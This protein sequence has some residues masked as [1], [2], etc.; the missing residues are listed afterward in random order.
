MFNLFK[1]IRPP[2]PE[3]L[4][5]QAVGALEA[6]A[7][8]ASTASLLARANELAHQKRRDALIEASLRENEQAN[9]YQDAAL[10]I[11]KLT[12]GR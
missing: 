3:A 5:Q 8:I 6:A 12:E 7:R 11:R 9:A 1:A 2:T 10:R 4:E